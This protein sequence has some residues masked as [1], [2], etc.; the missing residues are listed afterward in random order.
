MFSYDFARE[1]SAI[2]VELP[3][4]T[5]PHSADEWDVRKILI[6]T[7]FHSLITVSLARPV[8]LFNILFVQANSLNRNILVIS[9]TK[10]ASFF[11]GF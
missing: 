9:M 7:L 2:E 1:V 4:T 8:F 3:V 11:S 6:F 10:P 5:A